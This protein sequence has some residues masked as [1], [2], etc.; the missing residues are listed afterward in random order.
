MIEV[1]VGGWPSMDWTPP[2]RKLPAP[3]PGSNTEIYNPHS[4]AKYTSPHINFV[5]DWS[6][7][8]PRL[9]KAGSWHSKNWLTKKANKLHKYK[10]P[11]QWTLYK[12]QK[13]IKSFDRSAHRWDCKMTPAHQPFGTLRLVWWTVSRPTPA[14]MFTIWVW[15]WHVWHVVCV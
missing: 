3:G 13:V 5:A 1:G 15:K 11:L 9:D 12:T 10:L 14:E 8:R 6:T 7:R 2:M 4:W